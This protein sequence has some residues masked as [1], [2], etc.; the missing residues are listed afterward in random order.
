MANEIRI[1]AKL[2][3][4]NGPVVSSMQRDKSFDQTTPGAWLGVQNIGTAEE[5]LS[6]AGVVAPCAME[7]YNLDATNYVDIGPESSGALVGCIRLA[8]GHSAVFPLKPSV[9]WR[10]KANGAACDVAY[11][12]AET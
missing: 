5:V 3:V 2:S 6:F 9:V 11:I 12:L 7:I 4:N 10:A 1:I 8:P